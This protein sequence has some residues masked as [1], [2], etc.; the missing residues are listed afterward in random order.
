MEFF[1]NRDDPAYCKWATIYKFCN[2]KKVHGGILN[3]NKIMIC[4]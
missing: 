1:C 2:L 3:N 4:I